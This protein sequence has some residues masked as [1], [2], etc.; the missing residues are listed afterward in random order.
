MCLEFFFKYNNKDSGKRLHE[1]KFNAS[2]NT[3]NTT[4]LLRKLKKN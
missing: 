2:F 1:I 3:P 4:V